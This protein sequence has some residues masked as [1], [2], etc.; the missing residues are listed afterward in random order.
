MASRVRVPIC[1]TNSL[2]FQTMKPTNRLSHPSTPLTTKVGSS[3]ASKGRWFAEG[4][5]MV[6]EVRGERK[7]F[8]KHADYLAFAPALSGTK[9]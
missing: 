4:E 9:R 7:A 8:L 2:T 3:T 6:F 1:A 5:H